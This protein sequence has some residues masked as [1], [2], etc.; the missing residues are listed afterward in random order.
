MARQDANGVE[1][2]AHRLKGVMGNVGAMLAREVGQ[3]L[4]TM[5][6]QSNL[7]GGPDVLK[8]FK[9]EI[10]RVI[11]FNSDPAWE[12]RARECVEGG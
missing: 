9:K 8:T 1:A 10:G 12:Q 7:A 11:A 3:R 5:G 2:K 4:E 6:N